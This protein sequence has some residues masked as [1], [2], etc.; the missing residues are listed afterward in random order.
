MGRSAVLFFCSKKRL[1]YLWKCGSIL[2]GYFI[3]EFCGKTKSFYNPLFAPKKGGF[4][5]EGILL[6]I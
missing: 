5:L 2:S 4:I 1:S 3:Q 6:Q